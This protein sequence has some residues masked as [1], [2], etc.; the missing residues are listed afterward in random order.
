MGL[1]ILGPVALFS[2]GLSMISKS[3][4]ASLNEFGTPGG[5]VFAG[6]VLGVIYFLVSEMRMSPNNRS[7]LANPLTDLLAFAGSSFLVVRG[8]QIEEYFIVF[9]GSGIYTIH[10]LQVLFKNGLR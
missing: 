4:Y 2:I 10:V 6:T 5:F 3:D 7:Y 1:L 8:L 9:V